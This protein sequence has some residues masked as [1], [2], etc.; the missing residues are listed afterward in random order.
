MEAYLEM[1]E[2][3]RMD[4]AKHRYA[5]FAE[6]KQCFRVA[7]TV[8]LMTQKVMGLDPA[9]SSGSERPDTSEAALGIA[10]QLTN[11]LRM[12]VKTTAAASTCPRKT[13]S[14]LAIR[15]RA[16]GRHPQ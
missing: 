9:Y 2:G 13:C 11:I 3:Q 8:G 7:G 5:D 16:D 12:L 14:A 6:L 1:I 4:L 15:S 10:N